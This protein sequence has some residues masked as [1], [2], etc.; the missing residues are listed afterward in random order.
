M[1]FLHSWQGLPTATL[2]SQ[3]P[4][5]DVHQTQQIKNGT[6]QCQNMINHLYSFVNLMQTGHIFFHMHVKSILYVKKYTSVEIFAFRAFVYIDRFAPT[7]FCFSKVC[8][9]ESFT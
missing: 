2:Q 5:L 3:L 6:D 7:A 1:A 8:L 9:S 4:R